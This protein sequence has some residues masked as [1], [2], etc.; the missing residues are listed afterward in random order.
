MDHFDQASDNQSAP[1]DGCSQYRPPD[2]NST[3]PS[4][5][6]AYIGSLATSF[7][8]RNHPPPS[9]SR[10][11]ES[12]T[13][14]TT[15]PATVLQPMFQFEGGSGFYND[16]NLG[17]IPPIDNFDNTDTN[18]T[19]PEQND[20]GNIL[21]LLEPPTDTSTGLLFSPKPSLIFD[22]DTILHNFQGFTNNS[23]STM[24]PDRQHQTFNSGQGSGFE[25]IPG[26]DGSIL[27]QSQFSAVMEHGFHFNSPLSA[28][29]SFQGRTKQAPSF[30]SS[31]SLQPNHGDTYS[32]YQRLAASPLSANNSAEGTPFPDFVGPATTFV[33]PAYINLEVNRLTQPGPIPHPDKN[34]RPYGTNNWHVILHDHTLLRYL[35][36]SEIKEIRDHVGELASAAPFADGADRPQP[37]LIGDGPYHTD[38]ATQVW[39]Y[40]QAYTNRRGQ[41]RNNNAARRSRMKK[42]SETWHWKMLALGAG[43]PDHEYEFT[44]EEEEAAIAR[45]EAERLEKAQQEEAA[46]DQNQNPRKRSH[47]AS[48]RGGGGGRGRGGR[49]AAK[50]PATGALTTT[51]GAATAVPGGAQM[52]NPP[53][54]LSMSPPPPSPGVGQFEYYQGR[55][56]TP[57]LPQ[58]QL[59]GHQPGAHLQT[60]TQPQHRFNTRSRTRAAHAS[61]ASNIEGYTFNTTATTSAPAHNG[62]TPLPPMQLGGGGGEGHDG[63]QANSNQEKNTDNWMD[64]FLNM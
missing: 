12:N 11:P 2:R 27:N 61:A 18:A 6:G 47:H 32:Q 35:S 40:C 29:P 30:L 64:A 1:S 7:L 34:F 13:T 55:T 52:F 44:E 56:P 23:N 26:G 42:E 43:V 22:T 62:I 10:C 58:Q 51:A 57:T 63:I 53:H 59:Y 9:S 19:A 46:D 5:D 33:R 25:S 37:V 24:A 49:R 60:Q 21:D 28:I 54:G 45:A 48:S 41:M 39:K 3:A 31:S 16:S 4:A 14:Q 50:K 15:N 8:D 38:D 17:T 20:F 36:N